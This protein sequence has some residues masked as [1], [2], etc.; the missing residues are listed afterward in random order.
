MNFQDGEDL[1]T[2]N[3]LLPLPSMM[4]PNLRTSQR[5]E[6]HW[7]ATMVYGSSWLKWHR[8]LL[9]SLIMSLPLRKALKDTFSFVSSTST[10][11]WTC[12]TRSGSRQTTPL[13]SSG[14]NWVNSLK[15]CRSV[16]F[17]NIYSTHILC[18]VSYF[19]LGSATR[20][21]AG[22]QRTGTFPK[23]TAISMGLM[24]SR[25]RALQPTSTPSHMRRCMGHTRR[26]T[27]D[28]PT[29]GM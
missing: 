16:S 20:R 7:V 27:W 29:R 9:T 14:R 6:E 1:L 23:S 3:K 26:H 28:V 4:D 13:L 17:N 11:S 24:I 19:T 22:G 25:L 10:Y 18:S 21:M 15:P 8:L 12:C 5:Y 2:S